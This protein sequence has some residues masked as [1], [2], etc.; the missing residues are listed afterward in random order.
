ML[1]ITAGC[2]AA[3]ALR[4]SS[5]LQLN[6][7]VTLTSIV[8]CQSSYFVSRR[9][10]STTIPAQLTN[11]FTV[12]SKSRS[13]VENTSIT[14]V[15]SRTSQHA[16][17][18]DPAADR[19]L[20]AVSCAEPYAM[21]TAQ[22]WAPWPAS[23][24]VAARP[25]P[26]PPPVTI[27]RLE[28]RSKDMYSLAA[29]TDRSKEHRHPMVLF[30][31]RAPVLSKVGRPNRPQRDRAPLYQRFD[32][33]PLTTLPGVT[34]GSALVSDAQLGTRTFLLPRSGHRGGEGSVAVVILSRTLCNRPTISGTQCPLC[35]DPWSGHV[36]VSPMNRCTASVNCLPAS[37]CG[38]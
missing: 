19:C 36:W 3:T 30:V 8:R 26:L 33:S 24:S 35:D 14:A 1:T 29:P 38:T 22:T 11:T 9:S 25:M 37:I 12:P 17:T 10:H 27:T 13:A 4:T 31:V 7:P 28:V 20:L 18:T 23:S 16:A 6:M 34:L 32:A 15:G 5:A 2:V 21:S